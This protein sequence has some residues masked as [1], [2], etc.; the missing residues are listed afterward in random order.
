M[1]VKRQAYLEVQYTVWRRETES[2]QKYIVYRLSEQRLRMI[3]MQKNHKRSVLKNKK[4]KPNA[5]WDEELSHS[6]WFRLYLKSYP[7]LTQTSP[8]RARPDSLCFFDAQ[9]ASLQQVSILQ[10]DLILRGQPTTQKPGRKG[11]ESVT[12]GQA[13]CLCTLAIPPPRRCDTGEPQ[14]LL[15]PQRLYKECKTTPNYFSPTP[16]WVRQRGWVGGGG[17]WSEWGN[18]ICPYILAEV[19]SIKVNYNF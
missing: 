7:I 2:L 8:P 6:L 15:T 19:K 13:D 16:T 12:F 3:S 4:P 11:G 10:T 14:P 1:C 5:T 17:E 18:V 9:Q